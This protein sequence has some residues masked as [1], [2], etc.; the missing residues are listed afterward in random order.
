MSVISEK[1][2]PVK[3]GKKWASKHR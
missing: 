3:N 2:Q 1:L